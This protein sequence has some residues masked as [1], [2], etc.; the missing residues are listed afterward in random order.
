MRS[1]RFPWF[2]LLL[3][4]L[5]A[6]VLRIW[7]VSSGGVTFHSDEAI[8]ALMAR[9]INQGA[10]PTFFYGQPYMGSLD[11]WLIA[12]GF[13]ILGESVNTVRV[14]QS[15]LYLSVVASGFAVAWR[16]SE[17]T[18]I[19]VIAGLLLAVPTVNFALYTTATL[20]GYNELLLLGNLILLLGYSVV[21]DGARSGWQWGLLGLLAGLGWWTHALI[22]V[23]ALPVALLILY[24]WVRKP[25]WSQRPTPFHVVLAIVGFVVGSAPWWIFDIT[26]NGAALSMFLSNRQ[27]GEF[28]GIG[29][30]YV[31]PAERALGLL[32]IG[33]PTLIGMRFP[34]E[35]TYFL[36]PVGILVLLLYLMAVF[37]LAR[38][39]NP[40]QPGAR[41]LVL[42]MPGLF[43]LIFVASTFGADPTG[44]YFLPITL[45]LGIIL[46]A[47]VDSLISK[48]TVDHAS[49]TLQR[50]LPFALVAL[51]LIYQAAGILTAVSK[52]PP[53]LTTQFDL[54]SH[55]PNEHDAELMA[56]LDEHALYNG[57]TNYWVAFRL[58]FLSGERFQYRSTLPYKA[59]LS[60]NSADDRYVPYIES[61]EQAERIAYITTNLPELDERL[62]NSFSEQGL[63]YQTPSTMIL[64][65]P[66]LNYPTF[67][68]VFCISNARL[69]SVR[70]SSITRSRFCACW[71]AESCPTLNI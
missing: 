49:S 68:P 64:N 47:W 53:G 33:I 38:G 37:R 35:S 57:Y 21:R 9:H 34:W 30:T 19:A 50:L 70:I 27:T 24:T 67:R 17:K 8:V 5:I 10:R 39:H 62:Q 54:I 18:R 26:H 66:A 15:V 22:V 20:G 32:L 51:A 2:A 55:I 7:L 61:T 56:F 13:R 69:C 44:R 43:L 58:A 14:V 63:T 59:N 40:L 29:I 25:V 71:K 36:A 31:P 45:P 60:Y 12:L 52:Q 28:E 3:V 48:L 23:Y 46:G 42:V 11:A 1:S 16:F 65:H 6:L 41:F 4:L